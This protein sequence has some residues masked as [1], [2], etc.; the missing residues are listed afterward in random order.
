MWHCVD[1]GSREA[2]GR[3]QF[4]PP[5][6]HAGRSLLPPA[7]GGPPQALCPCLGLRDPANLPA[8]DRPPDRGAGRQQ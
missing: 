2:K 6:G 4:P 1:P 5:P 8:T 3:G 7:S